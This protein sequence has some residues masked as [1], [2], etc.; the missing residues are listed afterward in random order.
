MS[1]K[2][3]IIV[4]ALL[5]L[6]ASAAFAQNQPDMAADQQAASDRGI[7][8]IYPTLT[9][10]AVG[11][12]ARLIVR[13]VA[14]YSPAYN[15]GIER[16][17]QIVAVDGQPIDGKSLSDIVTTIR[18]EVGSPVKLGLN[19]QGQSR[20][21]SLTRVAPVSEREGHHM[22]GRGSSMPRHGRDGE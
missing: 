4:A 18:G 13:G 5:S 11:A 14:P 17:D 9:A 1:K 3:S 2:C 16:G 21:V 15:A 22:W 19:R 6:S 10:D 12:P 20:D 7:V 8:G